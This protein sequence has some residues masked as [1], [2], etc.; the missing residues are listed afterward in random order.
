MMDD[1][2]ISL[3]EIKV[4]DKPCV[5][6]IGMFDGLHMGHRQVIA[7][8]SELAKKNSAMLAVLTFSPHPSKVINMGRPPV[9]M[10]FERNVRAKMF[11]DVGVEVV[12][13]KNFDIEFAG[14]SSE[15]FEVFLKE[16]FSQLKGIVTGENFLYGKN[17]KGNPQT[18]SDMAE[19]CGWE[20]S[21]VK[22]VYLDDGRRM[23]SSLMRQALRSGDLQ[24]FE[25]IAGRCYVAQGIVSGGKRL[26]RTIGFPTLNLQ[27]NPDCKPPFGVYAVELIF[28]GRKY[29]GVANYGT[30]PTVG[31][32]SPVLETNLFESVDFGEGSYIS[33]SLVKFVREE[34][35][36]SDIDSLKAQ[37]AKDKITAQKIFEV[38][39]K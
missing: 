6:A 31:K 16:K 32:T 8:A 38:V 14:K 19:R 26:G 12:F 1:I 11:K 39:D 2:V 4:F 17:A 15:D 10:L 30:N 28:E 25:K 24:L 3:D 34:Q 22:G 20:Y 35:K 37:I 21:A 27:W 23:S 29:R 13:V 36:F 9:E 33:V 7:R 5:L 18:L